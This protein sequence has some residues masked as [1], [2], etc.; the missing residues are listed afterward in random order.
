[1]EKALMQKITMSLLLG[2]A[3]LSSMA[4][5][6]DFKD[7]LLSATELQLTLIEQVKTAIPSEVVVEPLQD[8]DY[9]KNVPPSF[10][11]LTSQ[12]GKKDQLDVF[13]PKKSIK[14]TKYFLI[15]HPDAI[16]FRAKYY[17]GY[18]N[19]KRSSEVSFP[20]E[21]KEGSIDP[22]TINKMTLFKNGLLMNIDVA[23][24]PHTIFKV[25][26]LTSDYAVS[27]EYGKGYVLKAD[28]ITSVKINSLSDRSKL[29]YVFDEYKKALNKKGYE[30]ESIWGHINDNSAY[31]KGDI[32]VDISMSKMTNYDITVLGYRYDNAKMSFYNKETYNNYQK[33]QEDF[34]QDE[35][36]QEYQQLDRILNK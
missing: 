21:P 34:K 13:L 11:V 31:E 1:M 23:K 6:T 14:Y 4:M 20:S 5:A 12:V 7:V 18:G 10:D 3:L 27:Y 15:N 16:A 25:E 33:M 28:L 9:D 24:S 30:Y 36:R 29:E 32:I 2:A 19:G 35:Y 26:D 8:Y 17:R 22:S